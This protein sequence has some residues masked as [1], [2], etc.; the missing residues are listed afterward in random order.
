MPINLCQTLIKIRK[1]CQGTGASSE[2]TTPPLL[3]APSILNR[4]LISTHRIKTTLTRL[5]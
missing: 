3:Q 2:T 4:K 5:H 1:K